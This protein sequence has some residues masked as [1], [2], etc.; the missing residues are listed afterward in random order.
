MSLLKVPTAALSSAEASLRRE[1]DGERKI[2]KR[3]VDDKN[4]KDRTTGRG[5][6]FFS[7]LIVHWA[8]TIFRKDKTRLKLTL[9]QPDIT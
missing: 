1:E 2:R 3:G 7:P 8:L 6:R 9:L 4:A 5:S